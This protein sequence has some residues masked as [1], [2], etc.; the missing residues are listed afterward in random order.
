LVDAK[1]PDYPLTL[2]LRRLMVS[3]TIPGEM[4]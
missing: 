1:S 2:D 4:W 3:R